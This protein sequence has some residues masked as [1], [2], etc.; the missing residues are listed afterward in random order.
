MDQVRAENAPGGPGTRLRGRREAVKLRAVATYLFKT[1]PSDYAYADLAHD[2][3]A[4]WEGVTNASA[5][6]HLRGVKKGDTVVIYH[7]G[8]E[9]S[10]VGLATVARGAYE[11]PRAGDPR[12]VVVDLQPKAALAR[13]VALATFRTDAV[14][15][16]T[17]LVRN[18]R[19]SVMPLTGAHL[20]RLLSLA[21]G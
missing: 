17:E 15:R 12:R 9:K 8:S 3:R 5:L 4:V 18:S 19:L 6:I 1:E 13:P 7:T 21:K 2:G 10:C 20:A 11:D 14:L 16:T